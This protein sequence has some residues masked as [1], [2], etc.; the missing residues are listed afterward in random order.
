M[1]PLDVE[2]PSTSD[3]PSNTNEYVDRP[4]KTDMNAL[5]ANDEEQSGAQS[6]GTIAA[7]LPA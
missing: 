4:A 2:A 6:R 7:P 1:V 5:N 3:L